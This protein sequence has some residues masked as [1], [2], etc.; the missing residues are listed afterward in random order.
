MPT[1]GGTESSAQYCLFDQLPLI[2]TR[3]VCETHLPFSGYHEDSCV[4]ER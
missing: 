4:N 3:L 1:N 2:T